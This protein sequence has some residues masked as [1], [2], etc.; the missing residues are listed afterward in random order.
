MIILTIKKDKDTTYWV[1]RF[2]DQNSADK[3]LAEEMTKP[4][5]DKLYTY[6]FEDDSPTPREIADF[7]AAKADRSSKRT[8]GIAKLKDLGLSDDELNALFGG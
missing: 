2:K 4:Y 8:S 6:S 7:E 5:W 3:W 1:E